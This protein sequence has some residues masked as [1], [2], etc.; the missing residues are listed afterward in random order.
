VGAGPSHLAV[1]EALGY[2]YLS[3]HGDGSV[4]YL[5]DGDRWDSRPGVPDPYGIAFDPSSRQLYVGNRG[6]NHSVTVVD[7]DPNNVV[8]TFG[9]GNEPYML[10][11]NH[12]TGHLFVATGDS[13]QVRRTADTSLLTVLPLP[14]GA[15]E[16][17]AVDSV[18]NRI[19]ISSRDSDAVTVI[20]DQ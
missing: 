19:Y 9:V 18:R 7:M 8:A 1:D 2:A 12:S 11:V 17:L 10:G 15:E 20:E 3:V 16:G 13:L 6:S 4:S 14:V 5:R